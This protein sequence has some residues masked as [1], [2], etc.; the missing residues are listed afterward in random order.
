MTLKHV[1]TPRL[2]AASTSTAVVERFGTLLLRV[3]IHGTFAPSVQSVQLAYLTTSRRSPT[4]NGVPRV[5]GFTAT[6]VELG[7]GG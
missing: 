3:T 4:P 5:S 6:V 2:K 1:A 7:T